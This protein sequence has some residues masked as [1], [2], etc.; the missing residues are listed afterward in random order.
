LVSAL[1]K[2]G[3]SPDQLQ[4]F[5]PKVMESLKGKLPDDVLDK[6]SGLLPVLETSEK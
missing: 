3:F 4:A 5:L 2:G 1:T 6:A